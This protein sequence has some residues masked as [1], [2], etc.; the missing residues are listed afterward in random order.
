MLLRGN[1]G[2]TVEVSHGGGVITRYANLQ[3]ADV[4]L[5]DALLTGSVIGRSGEGGL[6]FE[7][8]IGGK[9]YNP[10]YYITTSGSA[11]LG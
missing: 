11:T 3:S 8:I 6:H 5:G 2:L 4:S 1:L 7:I 10:L 9:P